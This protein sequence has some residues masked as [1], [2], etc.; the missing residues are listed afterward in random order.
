MSEM[1]EI[2]V[3]MP[4]WTEYAIRVEVSDED[5]RNDDFDQ[6]ID[7]AYEKLPGGLCY[8]CS[9]GNTG[10]GWG[11]RSEVYLELGDC[12]EAKYAVDEHG[13]VVWGDRDSKLGW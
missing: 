10:G 4:V 2:T 9:T 12:P 7:D 8:G 13:N 1:H 11:T 3:Y 6:A 5:F